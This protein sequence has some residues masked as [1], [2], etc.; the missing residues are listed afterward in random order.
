M[1][2]VSGSAGIG[3]IV[4]PLLAAAAALA[5]VPAAAETFEGNVG[6]EATATYHDNYLRL[7]DNE[8][9]AAGRS[10]EDWVASTALSAR[11]VVN[12][13]RQKLFLD[14]AV[15]IDRHLN[16][17]EY[18][19][20]VFAI[21]G[22][23]DWQAGARCGG[24][25][26]VSARRSLVAAEE[27]LLGVVT[28]HKMTYL[29]A[30]SGTC[31]VGSNYLVGLEAEY[32]IVDVD[33]DADTD[34]VS[35]GDRL[36]LR[37][38]FAYE[39]EPLSR[40]GVYVDYS[41]WTSG[42]VEEVQGGEAETHRVGTG[43]AVRYRPGTKLTLAADA[44]I[45]YVF[46]AFGDDMTTYVLQAK[47]DWQATPKVGVHL[48]LSRN[49]DLSTEIASSYVIFQTARLSADWA[50]ADKVRLDSWI[51]YGM[52]EY[53]GSQELQSLSEDYETN[54]LYTG[55]RGAYQVNENV[56]LTLT[57]SYRN[58]DSSLAA[59]DY[60]ANQVMLGVAVKY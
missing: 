30:G 42:A 12:L 55:V 10:R 59:A 43:V 14:A 29:A 36:A 6:L 21:G 23:A 8:A 53:A 44:G 1:T 22:G 50:V 15:G 19:G 7:D 58:S 24:T 3:R 16:N 45:T 4:R 49:V 26:A 56:D 51:S 2:G 33:V 20:E 40:V 13:D 38:L 54:L 48:E 9:P 5:T 27:D 18:D 11:G 25:V 57:Y 60:A 17:T 41:K 34:L 32:R 28:G 46:D 37:T 52:R 31:T 35:D 47:A 39:H